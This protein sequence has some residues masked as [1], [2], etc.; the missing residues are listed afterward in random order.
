MAATRDETAHNMVSGP[1][2]RYAGTNVL[3]DAGAFVPA[4]YRKATWQVA[5]GEMQIGVTQAGRGV[6]DENLALGRAVEVEF[7]DL[8]GLA[9]LE[10]YRGCGFHRES[11]AWIPARSAHVYSIS[12]RIRV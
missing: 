1:Y 8:E 5:V 12:N 3:D 10:K 2:L 6:V 11:P 9:Q 4:D 7:D